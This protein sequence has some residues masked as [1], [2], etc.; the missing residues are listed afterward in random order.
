MGTL[1]SMVQ[2]SHP[3]FSSSK[4]QHSN[5]IIPLPK[6]TRDGA[7]PWWHHRPSI[8]FCVSRNKNGEANPETPKARANRMT[9]VLLLHA[10]DWVPWFS[11]NPTGSDPWTLQV[12]VPPEK[13]KTLEQKHEPRFNLWD[14]GGQVWKKKQE[15]FE[16]W[17][18]KRNRKCL[19]LE[20]GNR[21]RM[22]KCL[23]FELGNRRRNRVFDVL[24]MKSV[25]KCPTQLILFCGL[26]PHDNI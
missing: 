7:G 2:I 4:G 13:K 20:I 19:S 1:D 10:A 18:R 9:N 8:C 16:S 14:T 12:W 3:S 11:L 17:N 5:A 6:D 26:H 24:V 15:M 25:L 21:K 23:N 22:R